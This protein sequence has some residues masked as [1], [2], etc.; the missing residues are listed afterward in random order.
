MEERRPFFK[1][2]KQTY[3]RL[4]Q[5]YPF[6]T[7]SMGTSE[8]YPIALEEGANLIRLGTCLFGERPQKAV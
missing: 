4:S 6:D 8:D 3:A 2:L 5:I 1:E 7:L